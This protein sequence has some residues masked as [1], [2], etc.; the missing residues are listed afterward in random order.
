LAREAI[1]AAAEKYGF[2]EISKVEKLSLLTMQHPHS[3]HY[4]SKDF[5]AAHGA[6]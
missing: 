2:E 4:H 5:G 6:D 1:A 3:G